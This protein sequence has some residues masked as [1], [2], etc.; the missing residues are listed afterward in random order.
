MSEATH[1][2]YWRP[3][4]QGATAS[5]QMREY[6]RCSNCDTELV[7]GSR[8]C[9]NCGITFDSAPARGF[10]WKVDWKRLTDIRPLQIA[11]NLPRLSLIAVAVAAVCVFAALTVGLFYSADS[12]LEWQAIQT[13]RIEWMLAAVVAL[14]AG[15]LLKESKV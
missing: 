4:T 9:H 14:L 13:W 2:P 1:Q 11:L 10:R 8:F 7:V 3:V 5:A 6:P 15:I 12:A